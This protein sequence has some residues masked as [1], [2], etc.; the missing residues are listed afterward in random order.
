[1]IFQPMQVATESESILVPNMR[2]QLCFYSFFSV[3][4][5]KLVKILNKQLNA[6]Y[7]SWESCILRTGLRVG[8]LL[9]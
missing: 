6:F 4:E 2:S 8:L 5:S 1:M 3:S 7:L 9:F